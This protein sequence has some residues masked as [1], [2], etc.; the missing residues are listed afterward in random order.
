MLPGESY[1][2][3]S[4]RLWNLSVCVKKYQQAFWHHCW[5]TVV[6][7]FKPSSSSYLY[8]FFYKNKNSFLLSFSIM[9]PSSFANPAASK[10]EFPEPPSKS[11][12]S[13][14]SELH[15]SLK[16]MVWAQPFFGLENENPN[17][18]L[19]EFEEMCSCLSILGM[20]QEAIRWKL[21]PFSLIGKV[22][23]WYTFVV[24]STNGD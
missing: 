1:N 2:G 19:H 10:G 21:F 13:S 17:H 5:G 20:T 4:M 16:A 8:P 24:E 11:N 22:K 7:F 23:Q 6:I 15:P 9:K 18:H 14:D 12:L 3:N